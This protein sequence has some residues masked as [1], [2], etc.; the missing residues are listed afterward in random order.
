MILRALIA[1][2]FFLV[3]MSPAAMNA[4]SQITGAQIISG[5]M[6]L[7]DSEVMICV[8]GIKDGLSWE[9]RCRWAGGLPQCL[10]FSAPQTVL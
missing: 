4:F 1:A 8:I 6:D 10:V 2:L 3:Q 5:V 9:I 7:K